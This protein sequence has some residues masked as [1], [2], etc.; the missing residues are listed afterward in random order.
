MNKVL[1]IAPHPDDE[2]LG[3]GGT[4]LKHKARGE[5]LFWLIVTQALD[6]N[7]WGEERIKK[8]AL[9]LEQVAKAYE[10]EDVIKFN[11]ETTKVSEYPFS[12][13]V[14]K[15]DYALAKIKP[16]IVYIHNHSDVHT[17]HRISFEAF[18]SAS[19]TFKHPYIK[20]TIMYETLSETNFAPALNKNVFIPNYYVDITEFLSDKIN[21][22]KIHASEIKDHPFPRSEESIKALAILRGSEI[23]VKYAEAF[24][25]LKG[26]W[27]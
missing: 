13:L 21:I 3:C 19:K 17:D 25:L 1:V 12:E 22:M 7:K 15:F 14:E 27:L 11:I 4:L 8:R 20:K 5:K 23:N 26:I 6:V 18:I 24:T 2:T 9:E 10:F 16:D